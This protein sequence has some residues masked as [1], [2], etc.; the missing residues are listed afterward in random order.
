MAGSVLV[1]AFALCLVSATPILIYTE[2]NKW[3]GILA[4]AL[5][6]KSEKTFFVCLFVCFRVNRKS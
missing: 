3:K 2:K 6:N 4:V 1:E 5:E